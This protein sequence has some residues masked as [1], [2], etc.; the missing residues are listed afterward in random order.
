MFY[1]MI[2][3]NSILFALQYDI[4]I[5][6]FVKYIVFCICRKIEFTCFCFVSFNRKK[7]KGALS[8][9]MLATPAWRVDLF[10][11]LGRA[12]MCTSSGGIR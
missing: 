5:S 2:L 12:K 7:N 8:I 10:K 1:N 11:G 9:G 4:V 6:L 3:S